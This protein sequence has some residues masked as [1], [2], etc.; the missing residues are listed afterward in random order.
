MAN[1]KSRLERLEANAPAGAEDRVTEIHRVIIGKTNPDG[2]PFVIV[3]HL[4]GL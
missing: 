3:R 2:S 1:I 4:R